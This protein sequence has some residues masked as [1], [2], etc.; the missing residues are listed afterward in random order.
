MKNN[1]LRLRNQVQADSTGW[2]YLVLFL[3]MV[4]ALTNTFGSP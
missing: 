1:I 4:S 2:S 3:F